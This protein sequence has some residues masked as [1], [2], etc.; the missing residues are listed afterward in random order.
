MRFHVLIE[1]YE[2]IAGAD[3]DRALRNAVG[4]QMAQMMQTGKVAEAGILAGRRGAF[5]LVDVEAAEELYALFGPEVYG[6][7]R[8]QASPVAPVEAVAALFA[9]W[10][11]AGR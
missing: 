4:P 11:Q 5:F 9:E 2:A 7:F 6:N 3:A 1:A 10:A 8:V